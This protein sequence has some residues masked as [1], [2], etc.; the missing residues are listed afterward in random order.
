MKT[1]KAWGSSWTKPIFHKQTL[2]WGTKR[3]I[4]Q[5][6]LLLDFSEAAH[7]LCQ[8]QPLL[9]LPGYH[10]LNAGVI[11]LKAFARKKGTKTNI[12]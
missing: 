7:S 1:H 3:V 10:R 2:A 5:L 8:P 11:Q 12:S 4:K 6:D 9:L